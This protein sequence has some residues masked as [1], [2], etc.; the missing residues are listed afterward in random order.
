MRTLLACGLIILTSLAGPRAGI[1]WSES[2]ADAL[3]VSKAEGKVVFIAVN[4]DGERANDRM[5]REVYKDKAII[6]LAAHTTNLVASNNTH[7][8]GGTCSRFG[9][10]SCVDHRNIDGHVRKG[11]LTADSEGFVVAPQ[12][13]FLSPEGKAILSVPYEITAPELEWCFFTAIQKVD[14]DFS[15]KLSSKARAPARLVMD[16]VYD[17]STE[18]EPVPPTREEALAIIKELKKGRAEKAQAKLER[19]VMADEP[20]ARD[21]LVTSLRGGG[22]KRNAGKRAERQRDLLRFVGEH[23]PSSY[24]EVAAEFLSSSDDELR[25]E[26]VVAL[27]QLGAPESLRDISK[28]VGKEKEEA[29]KKNLYRALGAV[30]SDDRR[31]RGTLLKRARDGRDPVLQANALL[32]LGTLAPDDEIWE[33]FKETIA[34]GSEEAQVAAILGIGLTRN[35]EWIPY[36]AE[37]TPAHT[38]RRAVKALATVKAVLEGAP[39][40]QMESLVMTAGSDVIP[41]KRIFGVAVKRADAEGATSAGGKGQAGAGRDP[42][43]KRGGSSGVSVQSEG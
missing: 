17:S 39:L 9:G 8:S 15:F 4:M 42:K 32:G 27:E 31:A 6:A 43:K 14:E 21:F 30:G 5:A 19:L 24:W 3:Q 26:A 29:I 7:N 25:A 38:G 2:F 10:I 23:S 37:I 11:V 20:E 40:S 28:Y 18:S 34:E 33:M 36:L 16:G 35:K 22:G 1:D 13:V 12:H 41:R